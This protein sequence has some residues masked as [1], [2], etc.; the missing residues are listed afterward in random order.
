MQPKCGIFST[1]NPTKFLAE[2]DSGTHAK[3]FSW[4]RHSGKGFI[5]SLE[6]TDAEEKKLQTICEK[7]NNKTT[8][9]PLVLTGVLHFQISEYN[10][11]C[12]VSRYWT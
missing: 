6:H 3:V 10:S 7:L 4:K 9:L 11:C 5:L 12:L 8:T 1:K 2:L